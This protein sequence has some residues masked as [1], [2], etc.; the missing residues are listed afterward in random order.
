MAEFGQTDF[1]KPTLAIVGLTD[2]AKPILANFGVL[3][4]WPNFLLPQSPNN[5]DPKTHN[6]DL[7]PKPHRPKPHRPGERGPT[8]WGPPFRAPS[9]RI[10]DFGQL[11]PVF[12]PRNLNP[13]PSAGPPSAGPPPPDRQN[14]RFIFPLPPPF[15]F[16]CVSLGVFSLKF[17]VSF[18][19]QLTKIP[20]KDPQEREGRMKTVAGEGKTVQNVGWF[21]RGKSRGGGGSR[22]G[23]Y[24][25][26]GVLSGGSEGAPKS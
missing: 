10:H 21:G 6:S 4:F 12:V 22:R 11:I 15:P 26:G 13:E 3:V 18:T 25:G 5:K 7:N 17:G 1:G 14:F 19:R 8:L 23:G 2:F 9:P 20:R 24:G 16:I